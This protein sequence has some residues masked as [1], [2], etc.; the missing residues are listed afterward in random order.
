M[1]QGLTDAWA[2]PAV[3]CTDHIECA[4]LSRDERM[5]CLG[6]AGGEIVVV[7]VESGR[8]AARL[9]GH[10][11][12][13]L[14]LCSVP[15]GRIVSGGE[16]SF[17]R[18]HS[19]ETLSELGRM[20]V[21][22]TAG[23]NCPT[24]TWVNAVAADPRRARIAAAAGQTIVVADLDSGAFSADGNA[25]AGTLCVLGPLAR[26][27]D[28]I[29]FLPDGT[30]SS[31]G[32]G[33]V[34][35]FRE[36]RQRE[37]AMDDG[38]YSISY[39]AVARFAKTYHSGVEG[40][41]LGYKGWLLSLAPAPSGEWIACGCSDNTVRLWK[42]ATGQDFKCGGARGARRGG[43]VRAASSRMEHQRRARAL[44]RGYERA[45]GLAR[46]RTRFC[47]CCCCAPPLLLLPSLAAWAGRTRLFVQNQLRG[48]G[49]VRP[50]LRHVWQQPGD[51]VGLRLGQPGGLDSAGVRGAEGGSHRS[52]L[53]SGRP[54][55]CVRQRRWCA[56]GRRR[57]CSSPPPLR[58]CQRARCSRG[59]HTAGQLRSASV[60]LRFDPSLLCSA[61]LLPPPFPPLGHPR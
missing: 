50:L 24:G 54:V 43:A 16:D 42:T 3:E 18:V 22:G 60:G 38:E 30:I 45:G 46:P 41:T 23:I 61:L 49:P 33:G 56:Q 15:D 37:D 17:V 57:G 29:A 27:I 36:R 58:P 11:G 52:C 20:R 28:C 21:E 4:L 34:T 25:P 39:E 59:A 2:Q 6:S 13:T 12:G 48:V 5:V 53:P 32:Y 51:A 19:L 7:E 1:A 9:D 40:T 44:L 55:F 31:C 26:A 35:L 14:A 10:A 47:P 8:V